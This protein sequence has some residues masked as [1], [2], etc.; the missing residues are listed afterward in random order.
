MRAALYPASFT[1]AMVVA[2]AVAVAIRHRARLAIFQRDYWR[3]LL[4][5]WKLAT[6]A[7]AA[8]GLMGAAPF[9]GDPYWDR[10][11]AAFM[12]LLA[13]LTAPW[14]VG[15]LW[16]A[17]CKRATG[18]EAFVAACTALFSANWSFDLYQAARLGSYPEIWLLNSLAT[19]SLYVMAGLFWS[20]DWSPQRG[21]SFAFV[22]AQW[23]T[24]KRA[25]DF[26]KIM[27]PAMLFMLSVSIAVIA[28]F[29]WDRR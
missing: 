9:M 15:T 16:R 3:G 5:P 21:V 6:F 29:V 4:A 22:D 1:L 17:L 14:V 28:P 11:D 24:R 27:W 26:A 23:P 25:P 8:T 19:S 10:V 7:I 12:S 18:V 13:F 20:L 2:V